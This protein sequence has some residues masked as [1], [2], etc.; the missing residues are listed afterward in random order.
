MKGLQF[1]WIGNRHYSA[2]FHFGE[3]FVPVED[4]ILRHLSKQ[5]EAASETFLEE[6]VE[7]IGRNPYL[8]KRIRA[9][10]AEGDPHTQVAAMK[11]FLLKH[12]F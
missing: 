9:A 4:E 2:I 5:S 12:K 8:K 11:A 1:E 10:A 6:V 7:R 3:S